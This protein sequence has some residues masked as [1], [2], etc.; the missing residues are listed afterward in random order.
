MLFPQQRWPEDIKQN[1]YCILV[2]WMQQKM[3]TKIS[4]KQK[5]DLIQNLY[6]MLHHHLL[7]SFSCKCS[8]LL[9]CKNKCVCLGHDSLKS[10]SR[11]QLLFLKNKEQN[12]ARL[13]STKALQTSHSLMAPIRLY[14]FNVRKYLD[15]VRFRKLKQKDQ[16]I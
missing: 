4:G 9:H 13:P 2:A 15:C 1:I 10:F 8:Y 6:K 16:K 5:K 12:R 14:F 3:S 11:R 7:F